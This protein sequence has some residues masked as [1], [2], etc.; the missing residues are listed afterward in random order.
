MI[1]ARTHAQRQSGHGMS[2]GLVVQTLL[3]VLPLMT[4]AQVLKPGKCSGEGGRAINNSPAFLVPRSGYFPQ[5]GMSNYDVMY[6]VRATE[7]MG[8]FV[9]KRVVMAIYGRHVNSLLHKTIQPCRR[10]G[11][12]CLCLDTIDN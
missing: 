2:A 1:V 3:L 10:L 4:G 9:Q 11:H 8:K 5:N 7:H 12:P 6:T